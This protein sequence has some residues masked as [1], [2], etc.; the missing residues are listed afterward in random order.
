MMASW[1]YYATY[2]LGLEDY[3]ESD[4][5][6]VGLVSSNDEQG[7]ASIKKIGFVCSSSQLEATA[8]IIVL[9]CATLQ[10][11]VTERS[12]IAAVLTW[13]VARETWRI[14]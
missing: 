2:V 6:K 4:N 9:A 12:Q 10:D 13:T 7:L 1:S 14:T 8:G 3:P 11:G 5:Q